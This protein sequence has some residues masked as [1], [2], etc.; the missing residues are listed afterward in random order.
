MMKLLK[1][2]LALFTLYLLIQLGF[3]FLGKGHEIDYKI[4]KD[5]L[6]LNVEETFITN[7]KTEIDSYLFNV[8]INDKVFYFQTYKYFNNAERIIE[9]FRYFSNDSYKCLLPIFSGGNIA[10]D[11]MCL[12]NSVIKYYH[13]IKGKNKELDDFVNGLGIA[14]Y[15]VNA[16]ADNKTN[17]K[18]SGPITVYVDNIVDKHFAGI[19]NYKGIYTL[20]NIN[21]NK[22]HGIKLFNND[23]YK[24]DIEVIAGNLY[25]VANY[26]NANEF[27]SFYVVDLI[28][29]DRFTIKSSQR[30]NFDS[31]I[32]GVVDGS[33]YLYDRSNKKQYEVDTEKENVLEVGNA[34]TGIRHYNNGAWERL[35]ISELA[36][37]DIKFI[38]GESTS[39]DGIYQKI[40][41]IGRGDTGYIYYYQ[42]VGNSYSVLRAPSRNP[43]YKTHLF[44]AKSISNV[45][46]IKD[47]IYFVEGDEIKYYH[48]SKGIKTLLKNEEFD[49][50]DSLK[51]NV[52]F[53]K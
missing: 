5:G 27:T 6:T 12:E 18:K 23:V 31:Y 53:K 48:D 26:N 46:Y 35:E 37:K 4:Y 14:K 33:I 52:Y 34:E 21:K 3:R 15:N 17:E 49:F 45:K 44:N 2:L 13:N 32:Q 28:D 43:E 29:N 36:K 20:N 50:N 19:N 24:R 30:I 1:M 11:V 22:I 10:V 40:D 7:T 38:D 42:K 51:Y 9:D 41:T 39:S 47:Y 25:V 16:W 8:S